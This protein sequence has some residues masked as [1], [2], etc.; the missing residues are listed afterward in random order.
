MALELVCGADFWCNRHC[1]TSP[2]VLEG[3][4][5]QVWPKIGRKPTQQIPAR[6]PSGTQDLVRDIAAAPGSENLVLGPGPPIGPRSPSL[7]PPA[8]AL[9]LK[10]PIGASYK[11]RYSGVPHTRFPFWGG[12]VPLDLRFRGPLE[13]KSF[14]RGPKIDPPGAPGRVFDLKCASCGHVRRC[15]PFFSFALIVTTISFVD[16]WGCIFEVWPAP[17]GPGNHRIDM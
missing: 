7:C 14:V 6:L 15:S 9:C 13:A 5:G 4:W 16:F 8:R 11:G 10:G 3:S 1:R 17:W 2:V 12:R